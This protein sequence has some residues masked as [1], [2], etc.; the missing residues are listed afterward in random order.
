MNV[1]CA[2][3][4][5]SVAVGTAAR[6]VS[7]RSTL[8]ILANILTQAA[9]N[10]LTVMGTDLEIWIQCTVPAEVKEPGAVAVPA[11]IFSAVVN[12]L[13]DDDVCLQCEDSRLI[14]KHEP[15][16]YTI[17][18]QGAEEFPA[19]P[20]VGDEASFE[21]QQGLLQGLLRTTIFAASR[22]ETRAILTGALM[23]IQGDRF[24]VVATDTHRLALRRRRLATPVEQ[25][26][27]VIVPA[28]SLQEL[29]RLLDA[30]ADTPVR[31]SLAS[32]QIEFVRD[33]VTLV[34]RVIDGQF[35]N[36]EKVIPR[37][38]ERRITASVSQLLST[39]R[40]V[41]IVAR[42]NANKAIMTARGDRMIIEAESQ[43]VGRG[44][45]EIPIRLEGDE[46]EIA[47]NVEYIIDVL[48]V[49]ESEEVTLEL[50]GPLNPGVFRPAGE[51]TSTQDDEYL[52][53]VM[54][55]QR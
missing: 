37:E 46:I 1:I 11:D 8:S 16:D 26:M 18:S 27:S 4:D 3:S 25:A 5:L 36:Y 53:V 48:N 45:E 13:P 49:L 43:E 52:Y 39:L 30:D 55:M 24:S 51:D 12:S 28:R 40:R 42:E 35:P 21:V 6:A 23:E 47:F 54:P 19:L 17:L 44:Y 22:D 29:V 15:S 50:T 10:S 33:N 7:S 9:E 2:K 34:S 31:I 38:V 32:N 14:V 20:E 41:A